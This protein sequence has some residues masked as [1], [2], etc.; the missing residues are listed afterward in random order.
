MHT[1]STKRKVTTSI[2]IG[3][4]IIYTIS[5]VFLK[6]QETTGLLAGYFSLIGEVGLDLVAAILAYRLFVTANI[7]YVR[8]I[9]QLYFISFCSA[10]LADG[11]Y[12]V[13]LNLYHVPEF[14]SIVSSLFEIPFAI[15]LL[16][17]V[18]VFIKI[19]I[20]SND[21]ERIASK[22]VYVPYAV[23]SLLM[24]IMFMFGVSWK[25]EHYSFSGVFQFIDTLL[26]V[27]GFSLAMI[28]LSRA[29]TSAVRYISTGYL[30][31][32]SSDFIIRYHV[33]SGLMP[34]LNTLEA[35]W[36]LGILLICIGLFFI[37]SEEENV[38]LKLSSID[39]LQSH[40]SIL[41]LMLW[42]I[43][44]LSFLALYYVFIPITEDHLYQANRNLLSIIIPFSVVAIYCSN[45]I[46][47]KIS[48]PLSKLENVISMAME[49]KSIEKDTTD[50]LN[51]S[52]IL[53][54]VSLKN[55]VN[56]TL[57]IYKK[58]HDLE[59][60]FSKT[61]R[62]VAHDI[63]SPLSA[64]DNVIKNLH[65]INESQQ[66]IM[67]SSIATITEISENFLAKHRILNGYES[68]NNEQTITSEN[69]FFIIDEIIS[70]KKIQ[71]KNKNIKINF[72]SKKYE[73]SIFSLINTT[74]FKRVMSNLI[75]NS[76]ESIVDF[77]DVTITLRHD[78]NNS[79]IDIQDTG[80]G[81]PKEVI[82]NLASNTTIT[83]N[84][85]FG[86]GLGLLHALKC[87]NE[88]GGIY[89]INTSENKG[90]CFSI[91]LPIQNPPCWVKKDL[92]L[93]ETQV[94]IIV[95]DDVSI[96]N[97]WKERISNF[98]SDVIDTTIIYLETPEQ[99]EQFVIDNDITAYDGMNYLFL[100]DYYFSNSNFT[101]LDII[102]KL[103]LY[104]NTT[105][106]TS[107]YPNKKMRDILIETGVQLLLKQKIHT[108][109][110]N[111]V[112]SNPDIVL[113]DD[114]ILITKTWEIE[115]IKHDK[116]IVCFNCVNIFNSYLH[117]FNKTTRFYLDSNL[118]EDRGENI[119][120][121]LHNKGFLNL[122][123]TTGYEQN[124]FC[125]LPYIKGVIGKDPS[126]MKR[127]A[128]E[129]SI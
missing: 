64:L 78:F 123:I 105:I 67:T 127:I 26:E 31:I 42:L 14:S 29:K 98:V 10:L 124:E 39:S 2:L 116:K 22:H 103:K 75:N 36:V 9:F 91:M 107:Q 50:I 95:D 28:C 86:N 7:C 76:V 109:S 24:F 4:W 35:F 47:T 122:Y 82:E 87:I 81:I 23:V 61:A 11:I 129:G 37:S 12:N 46:S 57:S 30:C 74:D 5:Y 32:V 59:M 94:I 92:Y 33:V 65:G 106:V 68:N 73:E 96:Y 1:N 118:G 40:I 110:I 16:L 79:I 13:I 121:E 49:T 113:L 44:A 100:V 112:Y 101:G 89:N 41:V 53:E 56:D 102:K 19:I 117:I 69:L 34:Y 126:F 83:Q 104:K 119:A 48:L 38:S 20:Y 71:F 58:K 55:F 70:E 120:K 45:Y 85:K 99:L 62:Q 108:I 8:N 63:K 72:V 115:A 77:G 60:E 27:A 80:C 15:F 66:K 21:I 3:L 52:K 93:I 25:I 111:V 84:K 51:E 128:T 18:L 97:S 54:F 6:G 90:T 114:S 125:N 88:W 17:Q 43:S